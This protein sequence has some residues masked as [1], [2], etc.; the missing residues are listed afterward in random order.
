MNYIQERA[1]QIKVIRVAK[2]KG[3]KTAIA[4]NELKLLEGLDRID[5]GKKQKYTKGWY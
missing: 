1:E 2:I 3:T 4:Q 5:Y